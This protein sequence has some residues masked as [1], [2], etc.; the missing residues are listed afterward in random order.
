VYALRGAWN[1]H[2]TMVKCD[3]GGEPLPDAPVVELWKARAAQRAAPTQGF[4]RASRKRQR[5][6]VLGVLRTCSS[7]AGGISR[8]RSPQGRV[9]AEACGSAL[10]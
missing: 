2:L 5:T 1:S 8:G 6:R 4:G 10:A 9:Q 7:V 3:A